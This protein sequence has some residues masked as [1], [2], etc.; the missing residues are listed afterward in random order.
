MSE[1]KEYDFGIGSIGAALVMI[2]LIFTGN[3]GP[4]GD[5]DYVQQVID[6]D[7]K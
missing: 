2:A 5:V 7:R 6:S 1:R 3:C 4:C